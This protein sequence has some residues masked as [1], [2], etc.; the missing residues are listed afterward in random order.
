MRILSNISSRVRALLSYELKFKNVRKYFRA[1][2]Y[3]F[4]GKIITRP[5]YFASQG[6]CDKRHL[7][8]TVEQNDK[9]FIMCQECAEKHP[10][11]KSVHLA[12]VSFSVN[13]EFRGS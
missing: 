5:C 6:N 4:I 10:T 1:K 3:K 13:D 11:I 9:T 2:Y 12:I 8:V 7:I